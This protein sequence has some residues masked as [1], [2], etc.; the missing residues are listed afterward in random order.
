MAE[1]VP[2]RPPDEELM[3]LMSLQGLACFIHG[4]VRSTAAGGAFSCCGV[5]TT[6][7]PRPCDRARSGPVEACDLRPI[8]VVLADAVG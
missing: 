1:G 8:P 7:L 2:E 3:Y 4:A 5:P 6:I